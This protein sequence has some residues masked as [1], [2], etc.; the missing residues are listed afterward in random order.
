MTSPTSAKP[1]R[2]FTLIELLVVIGVIAILIGIVLF[3]VRKAFVSSKSVTT[4]GQMQTISMALKAFYD[5]QGYYPPVTDSSGAPIEGAGA[6]ALGRW[7]IGPGGA[8]LNTPLDGAYSSDREYPIGSHVSSGA[9]C[10]VALKKTPAGG[11]PS[12]DWAVFGASDNADGPGFTVRAGPGKVF[13]PYLSPTFPTAG[14]G[15]LDSNNNGILYYPATGKKLGGTGTTQVRYVSNPS[16][17]NAARGFVYN[18]ADNSALSLGDMRR[19]MG[20]TDSNGTIDAGETAATS[21]PYIL[22][23][24]GPDGV[25]GYHNGKCDDVANFEI[26]NRKE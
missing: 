5:E 23:S 12:G 21:E 24:A 17:P 19:L 8:T 6:A 10:Y 26:V 4:A 16:Q 25:F 11:P 1:R 3:A 7:L 13:G 2:G 18:S 9:T 14:F 22:W 15:L 20:D